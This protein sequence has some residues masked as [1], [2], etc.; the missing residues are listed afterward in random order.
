MEGGLGGIELVSG[1]YAR[2]RGPLMDMDGI[3]TVEVHRK[4]KSFYRKKMKVEEIKNNL[5]DDG[6]EACSGTEGI[7]GNAL[8]GK[9][10]MEISSATKKLSPCTERKRGKKLVFGGILEIWDCMMS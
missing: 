6:G 1:T 10:D 8:K 5:S 9:V 7:V 4:G 2:D 3:D